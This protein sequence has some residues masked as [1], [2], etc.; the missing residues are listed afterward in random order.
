MFFKDV[1]HATI[2]VRGCTLSIGTLWFKSYLTVI[3]NYGI[4]LGLGIATPIMLGLN[5]VGTYS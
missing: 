4:N 3:Y 5:S 2:N 1:R